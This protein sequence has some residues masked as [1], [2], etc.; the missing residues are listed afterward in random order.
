M[1]NPFKDAPESSSYSKADEDAIVA[2]LE[3][4]GLKPGASIRTI[5]FSIVQVVDAVSGG[6]WRT[7]TTCCT[8]VK[9]SKVLENALQHLRPQD[10]DSA[11]QRQVIQEELAKIEAALAR[12]AQAVVEGGTLATLLAD[13]KK[14]EEQRTGLSAE[15]A[16]LDRFAVTSFDPVQVEEE[17]RSYL[18]DWSGLAQRHPA[19]A[20]QILRKLL[21][22]RVRVWR[23][24]RDGAKVYRFEGEA[25][26]NSFFNGLVCLERFGVP[27]G[28]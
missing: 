27:N 20:R 24:I 28:I 15:L 2:T 3:A 1:S 23:E 21:P 25:V 14:Y 22:N 12:L 18:K 7:H 17:L 19:Q 5:L 10:N 4:M 11:V 26:M 16:M 13:M 9:I 8:Q 6:V